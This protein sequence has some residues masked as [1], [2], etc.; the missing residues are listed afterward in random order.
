MTSE[1]DRRQLALI[2]GLIDQYEAGKL[3][4]GNLVRDVEALLNALQDVDQA[5]RE[6]AHEEWWTLEQVFAVTLDRG[7]ASLPPA[8]KVLVDQAIGKLKALVNGENNE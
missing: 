1:Y 2:R 3:E 7:H 5:W 4:L 6:S 8:G